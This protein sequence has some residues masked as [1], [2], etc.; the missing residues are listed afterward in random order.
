MSTASGSSKYP[1]A[2]ASAGTRHVGNV[3]VI[4]PKK[5]GGVANDADCNP[6][7]SA[8]DLFCQFDRAGGL[9]VGRWRAA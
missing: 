1:F 9:C 5:F 7:Q 8:R 6:E 3:S 2:Y 4:P